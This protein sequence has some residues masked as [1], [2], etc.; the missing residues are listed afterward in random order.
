MSGDYETYEINQSKISYLKKRSENNTEWLDV[1][2]NK[3]EELKN[4]ISEAAQ[5][6]RISDSLLIGTAIL[7]LLINIDTFLLMPLDIFLMNMCVIVIALLV[8]REMK[9]KKARQI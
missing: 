5:A 2:I 6:I 3:I 1:L 9:L 8:I 4:N 7:L